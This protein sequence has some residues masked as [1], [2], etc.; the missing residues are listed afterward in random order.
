MEHW[1]NDTDKEK[2]EVRGEK[3]VPI[4]LRPPQISQELTWDRARSSAVRTGDQLPEPWHD[5]SY[6]KVMLLQDMKTVSSP[7]HVFIRRLEDE[8]SQRLG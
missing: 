3:P 4:P 6:R 7:H 5:V 1:W 8:R 2:P